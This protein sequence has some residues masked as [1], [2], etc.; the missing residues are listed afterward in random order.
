MLMKHESRDVIGHLCNQCI[1]ELEALHQHWGY[2]PFWRGGNGVCPMKGCSERGAFS[3][4]ERQDAPPALGQ[5]DR[6]TVLKPVSVSLL[7]EEHHED[8][9]RNGIPKP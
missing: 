2:G 3:I 4:V 8:A 6:R 5:V 1:R 9:K 7:C